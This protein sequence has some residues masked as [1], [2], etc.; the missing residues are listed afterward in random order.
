MVVK[1]QEMAPLRTT[2]IAAMALQFRTGAGFLSL[3][4]FS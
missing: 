4:L 1:T 3:K 2:Q